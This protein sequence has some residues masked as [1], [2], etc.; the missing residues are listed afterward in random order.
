MQNKVGL[1]YPEISHVHLVINFHSLAPMNIRFSKEKKRKEEKVNHLLICSAA[2]AHGFF[3]ALLVTTFSLSG[4]RLARLLIEPPI[5]SD[6]II[7]G[8]NGFG[9]QHHQSYNCQLHW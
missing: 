5:I 7:N 8:N 2:P 4:F 3:P 6:Q 1:D 9:S